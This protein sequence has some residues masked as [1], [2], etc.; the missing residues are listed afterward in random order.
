MHVTLSLQYWRRVTDE[1]IIADVI[2]ITKNK[3]IA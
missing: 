1:K 3:I 2:I